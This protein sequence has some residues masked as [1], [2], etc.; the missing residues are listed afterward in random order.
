MTLRRRAGPHSTGASLKTDIYGLAGRWARDGDSP[1]HQPTLSYSYSPEPKATKL[2]RDL[3][4][5]NARESNSLRLTISQTFEAKL[6]STE[7]AD[8]AAV[9]TV[10]ALSGGRAAAAG[11]EDHDQP[12]T[13]AMVYDCE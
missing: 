9:D 6:A 2:Q 1:P 8:T 4:G 10:G 12:S 13:S 7:A 11:A 5:D 3:F